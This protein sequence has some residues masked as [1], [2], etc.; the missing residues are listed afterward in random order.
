MKNLLIIVIFSTQLAA[1]YATEQQRIFT[2]TQGRSIR[3][4]IIA[5]NTNSGAVSFKRG[6]KTSKVPLTIFS[7]KDQAYIRSWGMNKQFIS[8]SY[9]KISA[10]RRKDKGEKRNKNHSFITPEKTSF[11]VVLENRSTADFKIQKAEYCIY[12]E[13]EILGKE[14]IQEGVLYGKLTFDSVPTKS[15]KVQKTKEVTTYKRELD[16]NW[17]YAEG[18]DQTQTGKVRG[19]RI[20]IHAELPSG[21]TL[22]REFSMPDNLG[23]KMKWA[24]SSIDVGMM[25][26]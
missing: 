8:D 14:E 3:G 24:T 18:T 1:V 9:F 21:D 17:I 11:E 6:N 10:N 23:D 26:K 20:R 4:C 16:S 15:K 13:Q 12:Y 2:D 5:Y 7:D 25:N 22:I 19:I